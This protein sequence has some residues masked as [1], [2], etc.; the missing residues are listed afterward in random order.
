[1]ISLQKVLSKEMVLL[2]TFIFFNSNPNPM[3]VELVFGFIHKDFY[4]HG[5]QC[6]VWASKKG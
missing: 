4:I 2:L 6:G 1:M 5:N 3:M